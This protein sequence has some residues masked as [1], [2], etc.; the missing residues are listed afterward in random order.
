MVNHPT[1]RQL[2]PW[3]SYNFKITSGEHIQI[4]GLLNKNIV[5]NIILITNFD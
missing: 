1:L 3:Y 2:L 5:L 4:K